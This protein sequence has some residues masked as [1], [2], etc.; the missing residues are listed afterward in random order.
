MQQVPT[1]RYLNFFGHLYLPATQSFRVALCQMVNEGAKS[2]TILFASDGG[3]THDG[4]ALYTYLKALPLKI[5]MHAVGQI[6]SMAIPVFLA[7]EERYVSANARFLFHEYTWTHAQPGVVTKST[8]DEQSILLNNAVEWSKEI[9]KSKTKLTD[10]EITSLKLFDHP[11]LITPSE[12]VEYGLASEIREPS[13]P[14]D[15]QPRVVT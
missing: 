12:A 4:I 6:Q 9:I 7:A 8:M 5:T 10:K 3:S 11:K 1:H 14:A 13:I 15:C 2:V